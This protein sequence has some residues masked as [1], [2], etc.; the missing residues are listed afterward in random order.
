MYL[1][2]WKSVAWG[3]VLLASG[4]GATASAPKADLNEQEKQQLREL[5][6]QRVDEWGKKK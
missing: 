4:C 3:V 6:E 2:G 1:G 5:N